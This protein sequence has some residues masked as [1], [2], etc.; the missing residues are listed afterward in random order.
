MLA[1][2]YWYG[3]RESTLQSVAQRIATSSGGAIVLTGVSG[4]LYG[5]MHIDHLVF[6]SPDQQIDADNI[7]IA[8]SPFQYLSKG[9]AVNKL[10]IKT[11]ATRAL[12]ESEPAKMPLSLAAPF[13]LAIDD[14]RIGKVLMLP[15]G[16]TTGT[17]LSDLRFKVQGGKQSWTLKDASAVTAAGLVK[18]DGS[19]G[20]SK[21][22]K[23]DAKASLTQLNVAA[24]QSAAHL[25]VAATGDLN[26]TELAASGQSGAAVGKAGT[27]SLSPFAPIPLRAMHIEG[28]DIDPGFFNPALPTAKLAVKIDA[29]IDG[30]RAVAGTV[31]LDNTGPAGTLDQ[32]RLPL[33]AMRGSFGRQPRSTRHPRCAGRLRRRRQIHGIRRG[34]PLQGRQGTWAP[35]NSC[36]TPTASI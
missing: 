5:A 22:F 32:Q 34:R 10:Y 36:C 23:L 11:L 2:A 18:A 31:V 8:W 15:L 25:D 1:G 27:F 24:G 17:E 9:V 7:D 21:P 4:S 14:A 28:S 20:A 29:S 19:I 6:K 33:R 12:K 13:N 3:G 26:A 30:K 16:Q 35:P